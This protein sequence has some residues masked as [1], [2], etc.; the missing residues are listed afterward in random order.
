MKCDLNEPADIQQVDI[1]NSQMLMKGKSCI[2]HSC[3]YSLIFPL[4]TFCVFLLSQARHVVWQMVRVNGQSCCL[5]AAVVI[6]GRKRR[7]T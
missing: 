6:V 4:W 1:L 2:S 5:D 3:S 7:R